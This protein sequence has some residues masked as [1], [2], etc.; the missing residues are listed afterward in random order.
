MTARSCSKTWR[1]W[2]VTMVDICNPIR[3]TR[4]DL[5]LRAGDWVEVRSKADILRTLDKRGE[6]GS[7]PFMPEM[8]RFCGQRFRVFRRAHKTCDPPNGMG[9]RKMANAVHLEGLRCDGA[10]HGGCQAGC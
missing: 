2:P 4:H 1:T 6:L 7:L 9:G 3:S 5:G 8:F 10:A